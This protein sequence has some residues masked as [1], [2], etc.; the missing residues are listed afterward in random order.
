MEATLSGVIPRSQV[1]IGLDPGLRPTLGPMA[2][3]RVLVIDYFASQG[4][5]VVIGDLTCHFSATAPA[6]GYRE[7]A[8]IEGVPLFVEARLLTMLTEAGP[9]LVRAGPPFARHL[10]IELER[11]ERWIDFLEGPGVLAGKG[12]RIPLPG[13]R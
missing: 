10:R 12:A 11:P 4:C 3:G 2:A 9:S 7:L 8:A 13:P 1:S 5:G 6:P